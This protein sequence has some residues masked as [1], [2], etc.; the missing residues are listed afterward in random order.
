MIRA[1]VLVLCLVWGLSGCRP[2]SGVGSGPHPLPSASVRFELKVDSVG[3]RTG[4]VVVVVTASEPIRWQGDDGRTI[5]DVSEFPEL[6]G[7]WRVTD[8][9][10]TFSPESAIF[11]HLV[12]EAQ[13]L[14]FRMAVPPAAGGEFVARFD[15]ARLAGAT[16]AAN[17]LTARYAT[18]ADFQCRHSAPTVVGFYPRLDVLP[19]NHLKFYVVFS[20]SMQQG[21]IYQFFSLINL[22]QQKEVLRPFRHNELWADNDRRLTLWF[23]PGRQKRGVNLNEELG[24]ILNPG[25]RYRL[26]ISAGWLS[27]AGVPLP[28]DVTFEFTAGPADH[29][30]PE[31][32]SW[33]LREPAAGP[34]ETV[35]VD[36][37]VPLD[38]A[39]LQSQV[40]VTDAAGEPVPGEIL[41]GSDSREWRFRPEVPWGAGMYRV[42]VSSLL[43]DLAGNT[44]VRPFET[45]LSTA[46]S[47]PEPSPATLTREFRPVP[48]SA[49]TP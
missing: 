40:H 46:A 16:Q 20:E 21:D 4:D 48:G 15:P 47:A 13:Q 19:A 26:T 27:L 32:K 28:N 31:V 11:G 8:E 18:D 5:Q 33:T 25:D 24:A 1:A 45:D 41:V 35:A 36:L 29:A 30:L 22:T 12:V 9:V 10:Q 39:L 23:H 44:P 3:D 49:G 42:I 6:L 17:V 43:E 7:I 34:L 37:N 2:A 14:T 38:W